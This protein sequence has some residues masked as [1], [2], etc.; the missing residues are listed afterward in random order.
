M[1]NNIW[2]IPF[3]FSIATLLILTSC[4]T[5]AQDAAPPDLFIEVFVEKNTVAVSQNDATKAVK[6]NQNLK[7]KVRQGSR[8]K[9]IDVRFK[10]KKA[11][12]T[13]TISGDPCQ[14]T[15]D[16]FKPLITCKMNAKLGPDPTVDPD[17]F[18]DYCYEIHGQDSE[19]ANFEPLDPIVRGRR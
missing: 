8:L 9:K 12:C 4:A 5:T 6:S 10:D 13:S 17:G 3:G 2:T 19:G 1:K 18:H 15:M 16:K 11:N 14:N 7:W